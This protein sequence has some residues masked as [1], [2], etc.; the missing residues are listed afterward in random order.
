M[1]GKLEKKQEGVSIFMFFIVFDLRNLI[2]A[3]SFL[4]SHIVARDFQQV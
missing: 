3:L 4:L 1:D 2:S